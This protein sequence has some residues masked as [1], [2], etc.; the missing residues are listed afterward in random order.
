[1]FERDF[2][3]ATV[4][5]EQRLDPFLSRTNGKEGSTIRARAKLTRFTSMII[6]KGT[7][8]ATAQQIPSKAIAT[9]AYCTQ[10]KIGSDICL[11]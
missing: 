4:A 2:S 6:A 8:H 3:P 1:M 9:V 10:S 5:L 11:I 7:Q